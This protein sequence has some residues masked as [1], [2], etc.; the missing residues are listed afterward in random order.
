MQGLMENTLKNLELLRISL[1]LEKNELEMQSYTNMQRDSN[2]FYQP[3]MVNGYPVFQFRYDGA[4]PLYDETD[5]KYIAL[6]RNYY[7]QVTLTMYEYPKIDVHFGKA[8]LIIQHV[9][10]NAIIRDLDNRNRKYLIDAIRHTGLIDDD[11]FMHLSIV[12]EGF[13][14]KECSPYVNAF[15]L[16]EKHFLDFLSHK[17]ELALLEK[18]EFQNV[19]Q[20]DE[21]KLKMEEEEVKR[22]ASEQKLE[23][24]MK[25]LF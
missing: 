18:N 10:P 9:F 21:V 16:G 5:K 3:L 12:E 4:M 13:I 6:V 25:G 1:M 24:G 8:V 22:K 14:K 15:L 7:Y 2:Q 20:W 11:N 19:I 17:N 23:E